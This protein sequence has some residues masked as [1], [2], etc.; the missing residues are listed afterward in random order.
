[1]DVSAQGYYGTGT[2]QHKDILAHGHFGTWTF[3]HRAKQNRHFN[4]DISAWVPLCSNVLV[5]KYPCAVVVP[6]C[7]IDETFVPKCSCRNVRYRNKL[8]HKI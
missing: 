5:P 2:F 3:W 8:K 4:T 1:M 6:K 7:P